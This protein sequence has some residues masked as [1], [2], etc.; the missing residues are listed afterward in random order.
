MIQAAS[1]WTTD[2]LKMLLQQEE[3]QAAD[4]ITFWLMLQ[5]SNRL[6]EGWLDIDAIATLPCPLLH[7][8]DYLWIEASQGQFG[9]SQQRD[10]YIQEA[11]YE[12]FQISQQVGWILFQVKPVAFFKFYDFLNFSLS[13]PRGHL[14]ALWYWKLNWATSWL[15]GGFGTGRGAGFGDTRMLDAMMLRLDRCSLI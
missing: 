15:T 4:Q 7:E 1:P 13:A 10:I 3:W 5:A 6:S 11:Q 8:L 12:A 9:F 2:D 14:P